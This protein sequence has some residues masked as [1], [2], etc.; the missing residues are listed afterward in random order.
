MTTIFWIIYLLGAI[1]S[2]ILFL[3]VNIKLYKEISAS[4]ILCSL[5]FSIYSWITTTVILLLYLLH[6][7]DHIT[8]YKVK[9]K[10]GIQEN[11]YFDE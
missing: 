5:I 9:D 6:K 3:F 8:V 1:I 10:N 7:L 2:F 11:Y 4:C